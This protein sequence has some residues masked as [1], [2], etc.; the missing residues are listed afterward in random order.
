[1]EHII[2]FRYVSLCT[3]FN[4]FV[5][6]YHVMW[7]Y[8]KL[9]LKEKRRGHIFAVPVYNVSWLSW[10]LWSQM[11]C[12]YVESHPTR[13]VFSTYPVKLGWCISCYHQL[14][15]MKLELL[16]Y[17]H[18]ICLSYLFLL[19]D[20]KA[21][22]RQIETRTVLNVV[23][24]LTACWCNSWQVTQKTACDV[25][26]TYI[27]CICRVPYIVKMNLCCYLSISRVFSSLFLPAS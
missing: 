10:S 4:M 16:V 27:K 1:M 9:W 19:P 11:I 6:C 3:Y 12:P 24:S 20:K 22:H 23:C 5:D 7:S 14:S 8:C 18:F 13:P 17:Y 2:G 21:Q 26:H 15:N 25:I